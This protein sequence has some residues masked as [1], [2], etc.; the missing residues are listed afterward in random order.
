MR[1]I[2]SQKAELVREI[3][4][5]WA[6]SKAVIFYDFHHIDNE[7]L[8]QLRKKLRKVGSLWKVYK[9]NLIKRALTEPKEDWK[10]QQA[11]ALI[12]CQSEEYEPLRILN[13]FDQANREKSS[14]K[15]GWYQQKRISG[16]TL[17]NWAQLPSR[18]ELLWTFKLLSFS[19]LIK[20]T[21]S[22]NQIVTKANK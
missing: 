22:F 15:E 2:I 8:F 4:T 6:N 5:N 12:F 3:Q 1:A 10:V 11:N 16:S 21:R 17:T 14:I 19:H 18:D 7:E 20:L 9:N 13:Q